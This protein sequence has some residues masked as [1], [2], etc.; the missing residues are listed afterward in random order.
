MFLF[1]KQE[2]PNKMKLMYCAFISLLLAFSTCDTWQNLISDE[3]E[4]K[5]I[6]LNDLQLIGSHNSYKVAIEK[7]LLDYLFQ[8]DSATGRSLQ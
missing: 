5:A 1:P 4:I 3:E 7:P 2:K 6:M 8:L